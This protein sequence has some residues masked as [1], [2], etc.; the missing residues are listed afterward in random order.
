MKETASSTP[1]Q[2]LISMDAMRGCAIFGIFMVNIQFMAMP[3]EW[4]AD[5]HYSEGLDV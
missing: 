4:A 3:F 1:A 2:R 5:P